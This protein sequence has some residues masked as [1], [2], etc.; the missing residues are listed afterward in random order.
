MSLRQATASDTGSIF[1]LI[2][3]YADMGILL[4][5]TEEEILEHIDH[6]L[7]FERRKKIIGC[8]ALESY[9]ADL[10]EIRSLAVREEARGQGLGRR[11]VE[12]AL[13]EAR[14]RRIAR[15]FAVTHTPGFFMGLGFE[16]TSRRSLEEKIERDCRTCSRRDTCKLTAVV[17]TTRTESILLPIMDDVA[18]AEPVAET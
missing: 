7:V 10:A 17:A 13:A 1:S 15:V 14:R 9:G 5:R 18:I 3:Y 11:L 12:F 16:Q 2:R 8:V 6:F 4:S